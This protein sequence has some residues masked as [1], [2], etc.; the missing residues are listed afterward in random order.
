MI[1]VDAMGGDYAPRAVVG[2][3]LKAA[4][5]N[6]AVS[7]YGDA[8][9]IRSILQEIDTQWSR[10]P[11]TI[12]SCSQIIEMDEEPSRA[13]LAKKDSSLVN[14]VQAVARGEASAVV[15]AG[16]S[17]AAL[18]AGTLILKRVEGILRPAIGSFL[19]TPSGS[20]F[21]IDLGANTDCKVEHLEQ[22]A[23]MGHLYVSLVN[24]VANP[25]IALLSNGAESCK[26]SSVVK[27]AHE[28]LAQSKL[29][30]IGNLEGRDIFDNRADVLVCDGF[31]GNI[32]LKTVQGTVRALF[33]WLKTEQEKSWLSKVGFILAAGTFKRLKHEVDYQTKGGALLLGVQHPLVIAHGSSNELAIE[34][35]ILFA[36][37]VVVS[38]R[39]ALFNERLQNALNEAHP[40]A[41]DRAQ[42]QSS[43]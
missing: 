34:Q 9:I 1:A 14:S 25:R 33:G 3:A 15:S 37:R 39:L 26:G 21:G 8:D 2:G 36:H 30:F 13:T 22:F 16:N 28:R 32:M 43:L 6:I 42:A 38:K 10:L 17:G 4:Q 23:L 5:K 40:I 12:V 7:L 19:P 27:Q 20:I 35:A 11:I 29:N 18:V 31:V 24:G 41:Q